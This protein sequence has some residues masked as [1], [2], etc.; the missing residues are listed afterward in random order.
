M[1]LSFFAQVSRGLGLV[2][3]T[4]MGVVWR[5]YVTRGCGLV[6]VVV[7]VLVGGWLGGV[8]VGV[9]GG[10]RWGVCVW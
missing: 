4:A 6:V 10:V 8:I 9:W 5:M 1:K 2:R 3:M 7:V